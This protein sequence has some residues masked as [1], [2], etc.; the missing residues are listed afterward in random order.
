MFESVVVEPHCLNQRLESLG[1]KAVE[2]Q[3]QHFQGSVLPQ[4][5]RQLV[6]LPIRCAVELELFQRRIDRQP[7]GPRT[8]SV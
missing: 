1:R 2:W 6:H 8:E 3:P 5:H 4:F 7:A